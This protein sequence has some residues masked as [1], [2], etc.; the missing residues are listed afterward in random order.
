MQSSNNVTSFVQYNIHLISVRYWYLF[1][2][3]FALSWLFTCPTQSYRIHTM[4]V[5]YSGILLMDNIYLD[6]VSQ[7]WIMTIIYCSLLYRFMKYSSRKEKFC[8]I[9]L[10]NR[11]SAPNACIHTY[12]LIR[13]VVYFSSN[14]VMDRLTHSLTH[15]SQLTESAMNQ[16]H[17]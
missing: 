15:S 6:I 1:K 2:D 16:Y 17:L 3:Y 10:K 4:L 11:N 9:L 8:W 7:S 13:W 12:S 5:S 14:W